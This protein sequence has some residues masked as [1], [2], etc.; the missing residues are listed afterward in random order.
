[1]ARTCQEFYCNDCD[2]F[3]FIYLQID[4][5]DRGVVIKCPKCNREHPRNIIGGKIIDDG[6]HSQSKNIV[7]GLLSTW[8]KNPRSAITKF[9]RDSILFAP[10]VGHQKR[11]E[12]ERKYRQ[13]GEV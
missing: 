13:I 1:M 9:A 4:F 12:A 10:S 7:C 3:F 5:N 6:R 2:G 8:S 11:D